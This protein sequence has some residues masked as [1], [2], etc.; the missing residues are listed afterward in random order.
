MFVCHGKIIE[1][2]STNVCMCM[3]RV[4]RGACGREDGGGGRVEEGGRGQEMGG[5]WNS[6]CREVRRS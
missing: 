5:I 2:I 1:E 3:W 4:G 6:Y